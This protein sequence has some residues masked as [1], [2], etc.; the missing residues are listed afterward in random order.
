MVTTR[1]DRIV[2]GVHDAFWAWCGSGE[3]RLQRCQTCAELAW[4]PVAACENCGSDVLAWEAMSGRGRIAS[5]CRFE[6]DYYKG[7]FPLPWDTILVE[8]D[9]GPFFISNP[10]NFT[11]DEVEYGMPVT[12]S[13]VPCEDAHGAFSLPVFD[14]RRGPMARDG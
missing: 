1:P 2:G 8:L 12:V 11:L 10:A 3:L 7:L 6:R 9:E 14:A 4:P 5:W 13:F